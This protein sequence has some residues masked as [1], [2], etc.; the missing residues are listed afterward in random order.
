MSDGNPSGYLPDDPRYG[1][2]GE[3]LKDYYRTK[4]AQWAIYCWDKPGTAATRRALPAEQ[5][6]YIKNFGERVIGYG[7]FVSDDG[8]WAR[9]SS[10][11][12]TTAPRQKSS[13]PANR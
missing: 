6:S 4:P 5:K 9:R 10:R 1:L 12:S 13:S 2:Q 11:S 3:A 7:H 8:R